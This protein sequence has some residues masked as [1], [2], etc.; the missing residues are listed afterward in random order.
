[1]FLSR[2]TTKS[3]RPSSLANRQILSLRSL[4]IQTEDTPNDHALKF[5][6][7]QTI[8]PE[9]DTIEY[10]SGREAAASPLARKLFAVDGVKTVMFGGNFI[11][12]EK[13]PN[14]NWMLIKPEVFSILTESLTSGEPLFDQSELPKDTAYDEDDDDVVSMIKELIF[15]RIRPAI[16]EDGGDIEFVKY[17]ED[18]GTVWLKLMGACR[19]CDS[20]SV[21][22]KNGIE[23]MLK[24][25]IEEVE[26]VKQIEE[27]NE[28]DPLEAIKLAKEQQ[29]QQQDLPP[30]PSI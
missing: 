22:L 8:L 10:T 28:K 6:P 12:V 29:Q 25:Y 17:E 1:M 14:Y 11:T 15:T 3:L 16:Q 5:L 2:F 21:T 4:F 7:S 20:S 27:E 18:S 24:H 13:R 30:P 19:S 23:S 26:E 9:G